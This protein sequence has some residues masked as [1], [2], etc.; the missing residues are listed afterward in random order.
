MFRAPT[1]TYWLD[2]EDRIV[3]VCDD[4]DKFARENGA[5]SSCYA[6]SVIGRHLQQFIIGE[7]TRMYVDTV[8]Q[9]A[10]YL[11]VVTQRHYRCDSPHRR[12]HMSMTITPEDG[13]LCVR[14][15]V[16]REQRLIPAVYFEAGRNQDDPTALRRCSSC[17][18]LSSG[19]SWFDVSRLDG[20]QPFAVVYQVCPECAAD[21]LPQRRGEP[22]LV[23]GR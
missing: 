20:E 13:L 18:R 5:N 6:K 7:P 17:L 1:T 11:G 23:S 21:G 12:R 10:R 22:Q 2:S 9:R 15:H 19:R 4:W 16:V 3:R 14:H 8:M